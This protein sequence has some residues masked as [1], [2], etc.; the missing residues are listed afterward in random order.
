[1]EGAG[2][3]QREEFVEVPWRMYTP[4]AQEVLLAGG[5]FAVDE[6]GGM[7]IREVQRVT[8]SFKA[9]IGW[10]DLEL[11]DALEWGYGT[12]ARARRGCESSLAPS[13]G[14][15]R[16][17]TC[18]RRSGTRMWTRGSCAGG[19]GCHGPSLR[20]RGAPASS[21]KGRQWMVRR[22]RGGA[23]WA[24]PTGHWCGCSA[25]CG[26]C[27]RLRVSTRRR[28]NCLSCDGPCCSR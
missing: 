9:A 12:T 18:C 2:P 5:D 26:R 25:G 13:R 7:A 15:W 14:R 23:W 10:T 8:H 6:V 21:R 24:A 17:R 16:T 28:G 11:L 19:G 22:S 4:F 3:Q 1:M 20:G 27:P